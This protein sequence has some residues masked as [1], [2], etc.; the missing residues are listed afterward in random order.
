MLLSPFCAQLPA[1]ERDVD[2]P[3]PAH[4]PAR[5]HAHLAEDED[6]RKVREAAPQHL[7]DE[8]AV[9]IGAGDPRAHRDERRIVLQ[10]TR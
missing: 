5:L 6:E 9:G 1:E 3:A 4:R 10:S 7:V 8:A 2:H